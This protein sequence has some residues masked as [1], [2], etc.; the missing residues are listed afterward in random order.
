MNGGEILI[1]NASKGGEKASSKKGYRFI[2]SLD[3]LAMPLST[4]PA[5][6]GISE[7]EKGF[8]SSI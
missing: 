7:L 6:F 8:S 3:F 1:F 4:F 2:D 5:T